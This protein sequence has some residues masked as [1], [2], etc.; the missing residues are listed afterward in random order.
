MI[1]DAF[2]LA[3][4]YPLR[5]VKVGIDALRAAMDRNGVDMAMTMSLRAVQTDAAAGNDDLL[6]IAAEDRR[7]LPVCV[8]DPRDTTRND[9]LIN[10]AVARGAVA[11]AFVLSAGQSPV[12]LHSILTRRS[13]SRRH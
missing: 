10:N 11:F 8:I 6:K 1:I 13:A 4:G 2:T 12:P 5:P 7:I 9:G 3:G